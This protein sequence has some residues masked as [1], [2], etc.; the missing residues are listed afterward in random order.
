M[1]ARK[2][3]IQAIPNLPNKHRDLAQPATSTKAKAPAG[4]AGT[5][6][7]WTASGQWD[8]S[9]G[10]KTA[11]AGE[12]MKGFRNNAFGP[13]DKLY[14]KNLRTMLLHMQPA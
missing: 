9:A 1:F 7:H 8:G 4:P 3:L 14:N 13:G 6:R 12:G 2:G 5:K 10:P 11:K